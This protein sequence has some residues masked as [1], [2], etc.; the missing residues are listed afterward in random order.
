MLFYKPIVL[1]VVEALRSLVLDAKHRSGSTILLLPL[2]E[3]AT[4]RAAIEAREAWTPGTTGLVQL[5]DPLPPGWDVI[6]AP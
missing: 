4:E 2:A 6:A 3:G 1:P 5:P